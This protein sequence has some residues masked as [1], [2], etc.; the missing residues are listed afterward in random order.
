MLPCF[1]GEWDFFARQQAAMHA[2]LQE[3]VRD[4]RNAGDSAVQA[5]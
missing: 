5:A 2:S 4:S 3:V 1:G